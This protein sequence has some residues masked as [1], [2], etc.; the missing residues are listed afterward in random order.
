MGVCEV[1]ERKGE[2]KKLIPLLILFLGSCATAQ[3]GALTSV[4]PEK[5][6]VFMTTLG[7]VT[8]VP[9]DFFSEENHKNELWF[10]L[11]E[12]EDTEAS[13]TPEHEVRVIR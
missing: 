7:F 13:E 3:P 1:G 8:I 5:D 9:K 2:M 10:Y 11:D 6:A 12:F 4:C